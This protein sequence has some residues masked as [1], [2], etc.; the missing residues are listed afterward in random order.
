MNK[1][2]AGKAAEAAARAAAALERAANAVEDDGDEPDKDLG[3]LFALDGEL[4]D[5]HDRTQIYRLEPIDEGHV[6][7]LPPESTIEDIRSRWGGGRFRAVA[8]DEAGAYLKRTSQIRIGGDPIFDNEIGAKKYDRWLKQTF[9]K[10]AA[11]AAGGRGDVDPEDA[12]EARHARELARIKAEN[13]A[14]LSRL[15]AEV[16]AKEAAE[17]RRRQRE[18][19]DREAADDRRRAE[20]RADRERERE[21]RRAE[22]EERLA[23]EERRWKVE[24]EERRADRESRGDPMAQFAAMAQIVGAMQGSGGG[25]EDPVTAIAS[26]L[27]EILQEARETGAAMMS[28]GER[29]ERAPRRRQVEEGDDASVKL[30]GPIA[31]KAM[32]AI[33]RLQKMGR[34][35]EQVLDRMFSGIAGAKPGTAPPSR[36]LPPQMG[37]GKPTPR[38]PPPRG[39]ANGKPVNAAKGTVRPK[40][41]T[42]PPKTEPQ[43]S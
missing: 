19:E 41:P 33:R 43:P 7:D 10:D 26:R 8:V 29:R 32:A 42:T 1:A 15:R 38:K 9:G 27:P 3:P 14:S 12:K 36:Q 40:P 22:R 30:E 4:R 20:E 2:N 37:K 35:P 13:E 23:A 6:G 11:P 34:D 31:R 21:E 25:P 24:I 17:E 39:R 28:G 18:R 5:K 16:E